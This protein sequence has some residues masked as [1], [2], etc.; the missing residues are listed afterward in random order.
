V[1]LGAVEAGDHDLL[2]LRGL[3]LEPIGSPASGCVG[4]GGALRHDAFEALTLGLSEELFAGPFAVTAERD[5]LVARQN[6]LEPL[7]A[8][9]ERPLPQVLSVL[10]HKIESAVKKL[11][12]MAQRVLKKLEMRHPVLSDRDEFPVDH[13]DRVSYARLMS[14]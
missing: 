6:G 2:P 7:L 8:F 3:Y 13:V 4:A 5:Q 1:R 10:E 9:E 12:L 14:R 11:R